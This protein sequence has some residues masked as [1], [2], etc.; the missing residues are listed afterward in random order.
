MQIE[1]TVHQN[2]EYKFVELPK[3][4]YNLLNGSLIEGIIET[5]RDAFGPS[6]STEEIKDHIYPTDHLY[7]AYKQN[8]IVGFATAIVKE[9]YIDLV[10]AAIREEAQGSSIYSDFV[11]K[12]INLA[13][14]E[15]KNAI[16]LRTQ[17]PRVY[18]GVQ[19]C[20]ESISNLGLIE[21]YQIQ[22]E[23]RQEL[24]SRML[25]DKQPYC[26]IAEIDALFS[27]LN[28]QRGDA[29]QIDVQMEVRP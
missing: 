24:Y 15:K 21:G 2:R 8:R 1:Q 4:N 7:L 13:L 16:Q 26:N 5:G 17:N 12:R 28:Y 29:F 25:T 11:L 20:L 3:Q 14:N 9:D 22:Q 6:M 18:L 27:T 10:G 19:R 23:L